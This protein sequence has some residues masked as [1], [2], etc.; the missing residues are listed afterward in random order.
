ML[1]DFPIGNFKPPFTLL[2]GECG[3]YVM[4]KSNSTV[5]STPSLELAEFVV[6]YGN[7]VGLHQG[8]GYKKG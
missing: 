6:S 7:F 5:L 8:W 4:D 2:T 1:P 3:N